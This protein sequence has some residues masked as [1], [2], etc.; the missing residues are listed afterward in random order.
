MKCIH[1]ILQIILKGVNKMRNTKSG[2]KRIKMMVGI[3]TYKTVWYSDYLRDVNKWSDVEIK[4]EL[5]RLKSDI[6][7]YNRCGG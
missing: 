5:K 3:N 2:D 4:I 7:A 1:S 6:N